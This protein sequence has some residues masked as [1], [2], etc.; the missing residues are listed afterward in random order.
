[1]AYEEDNK[2]H[3]FRVSAVEFRVNLA[4]SLLSIK[5]IPTQI[6]EVGA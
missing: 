2:I 6:K 4:L 3:N 5:F 1:M